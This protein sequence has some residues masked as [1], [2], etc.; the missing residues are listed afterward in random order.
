M[1]KP[2]PPK[3]SA[4]SGL[5]SAHQASQMMHNDTNPIHIQAQGGHRSH[6]QPAG[7][8]YTETSSVNNYVALF[9]YQARMEGDLSFNKGERL[10]ILNNNQGKTCCLPVFNH[11]RW[12][13]GGEKTSNGRAWLCPVKLCRWSRQYKGERVVLRADSQGWRWTM[14]RKSSSWNF[15]YSRSRNHGQY[16]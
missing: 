1:S 12:L 10:I 3:A 5:P 13:V 9:D 6:A 4:G 11:F 2:K 14:P 7:N 8:P 16:V 15:S